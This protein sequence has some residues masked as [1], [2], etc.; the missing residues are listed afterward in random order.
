[1]NFYVNPSGH[2]HPSARSEPV[3]VLKALMRAGGSAVRE[4]NRKQIPRAANPDYGV[5]N[6]LAAARGRTVLIERT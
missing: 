1:M 2:C 3:I 6:V 5:S 4:C